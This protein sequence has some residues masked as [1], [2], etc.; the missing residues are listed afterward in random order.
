M[1]RHDA[2]AQLTA[3]GINVPAHLPPHRCTH[4][5]LG[6]DALETGDCRRRTRPQASFLDRVDGNQVDVAEHV[7]HKVG[8]LPGLAG[9]VIDTVDHG[10]F[11]GHAPTRDTGVLGAGRNQLG[12]RKTAVDGHQSGP[13]LIVR[14]MQRDSE[15][16]RHPLTGQPV[17]CRDDAAG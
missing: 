1:G 4:A 2:P 8:Q 10:V 9:R 13:E 14:G 16:D 5:A 11:E 12:K 17:D 3:S 6:K 15:R 7:V